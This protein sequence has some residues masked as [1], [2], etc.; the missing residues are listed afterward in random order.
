MNLT[1]LLFIGAGGF[2]GA[3]SRFLIA[4][5][6]QK[7][8]GSFFP[9]GTLSVNVLGSFIIGFAAMFFAQSV[10]PEY[11]AFVITGFLGALTTFS[12]FSLE[13]V[14]MLQDGEFTS[15]G[16]NIFLNVTLTITATI[17]AVVLFKKLYA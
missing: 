1:L 11:K 14:N 16:I 4:T 12:T 5:N 10:Q 2:F 13:N 3:I 8:S 7:F 15:F 6:V 17:L 9:Y